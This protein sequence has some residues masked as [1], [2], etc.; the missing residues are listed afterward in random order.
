MH[1]GLRGK[2]VREC[3]EARAAREGGVRQ[4]GNIMRK[5]A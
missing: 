1:E 3:G 5:C 2:W 4:W